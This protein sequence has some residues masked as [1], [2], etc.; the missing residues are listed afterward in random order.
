MNTPWN[1]RS[2]VLMIDFA[3]F[4]RIKERIG[5]KLEQLG[6]EHFSFS[7]KATRIRCLLARGFPL[8][9]SEDAV[10]EK[11]R[12]TGLA[13]VDFLKATRLTTKAPTAAGVQSILFKI[14]YVT[15]KGVGEVLIF[16]EPFRPKQRCRSAG[17][18]SV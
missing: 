6:I 13:A 4:Q 8:D 11:L 5:G 17:G 3:W 2:N 15:K 9:W 12:A 7:D 16:L 10:L 18:A 1:L 14:N